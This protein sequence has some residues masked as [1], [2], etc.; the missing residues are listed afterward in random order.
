MRFLHFIAAILAT[1]LLQSM[2]ADARENHALLI[3]ASTYPNLDQKY[4][5]KGPANDIELVAR[6][7]QTQATVPF[8]ADNVTILA[9]GV[10]GSTPPTL[11]AIRSAFS[12]LQSKIASGDF[13]YLHFSGHGS[14]AP[15][16][17]PASEL[18][19]LDEL[20]LP[21]DIGPWND[22]TGEVEN[23]LV[24]D[25][26]GAMIAG[27]R[28]K[29]ATVWAV[30]DSCHSGTVTRGAPAGDS[31]VLMRKLDSGA[32]GIPLAAMDA[33][34]TP[35]TRGLPDP[36]ARAE[37]PIKAGGDGG[38]VAFFAA[39]TNEVT[40]EMRLP[41]GAVDRRSQGVFTFVLFETLARNPGIT[42]RQLGQ[43]ILRRYSVH[44]LAQ[45]TPLFEGD[46]D[47]VTFSGEKA[48]AI[49]QWP[50]E[51]VEDGLKIAA[52]TLHDLTVGSELALVAAPGDSTETAL[53][54]FRVA[55][56]ET[57]S[58]VLEP[59]A[60][61]GKPLVALKDVP[62]GALLR[63]TG[64]ELD[65]SLTVAMPEAGGDSAVAAAFEKAI[66][67]LRRSEDFSGRITFVAAGAQADIR[68]A[69]LPESTRPDAVWMM[70]ASGFLQETG[71]G[72]T[73]SISISDKTTEDL[74]A[75]LADNLTRMARAIN[76]LKVGGG[77]GTSDMAVDVALMTRNKKD[78][79]LRPLNAVAVP[80]LIPGDEVHVVAKNDAEMPV[81]I[82][83]LYVG[84][85]YS[86]SHFYAGRLQ[87]GDELKKGL[88]RITDKSYGRDRVVLV[89]TPA[90]PQ[91]IVENLS[92]LKQDEISA[93]RGTGT[94][95]MAGLLAEAG[96]GTTTRSAVA[97]EDEDGGPGG[98]F[99]QFELDTVPAK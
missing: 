17:D 57:F 45:T 52:G 76:L 68:L 54:Y 99:Y 31:E 47:T 8:S 14:Q 24:D 42:Y 22:T 97:L 32:L 11:A 35:T 60:L 75:V 20:F 86:I 51:V 61:N 23:A 49:S 91:T 26:I 55:S 70:P 78:K 53:G 90:K 6:F 59:V 95:G 46:L 64:S 48:D 18:D 27:L 62:N 58:S 96:F 40:P 2:A 79:T 50:A 43:E 25:E 87:P 4:W 66:E 77:L 39:Q 69:I 29:G 15:A 28:S 82:N 5:L 44:N 93:T 10:T 67:Q 98:Q 94:K 36:R 12:A 37:S 9:D 16:Q 88:L 33:A 13:V 81:D 84:S 83:V 21:V 30:F 56:S 3:G 19:G 63:K 80:R 74:Q 71:P 73:P 85:D 41:K 89:V 92:F 38:F 7:L 1:S 72:K 65:F 34:E